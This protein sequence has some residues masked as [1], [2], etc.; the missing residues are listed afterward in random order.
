LVEDEADHPRGYVCYRAAGPIAI[1]GKADEP[2]WAA[3]PWTED[4][5][6]IEGPAKPTPRF[7]SRAK[8]LWD[9]EY[10]YVYAELHEPHVWGTI[11]RKNEVIF[12]DN[13]FEVFINP[14]GDNHNYYE[15][16]MNALNT[17]WELTLDRRI[18]TTG[19]FI[20]GRTWKG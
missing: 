18:G 4:F 9:D 11:T 20:W 17:I 8:M 12:R 6:D 19:R 14:N 10:L 15:Y 16:E 3:V 1:D 5:S 2:S 7:R 13:D